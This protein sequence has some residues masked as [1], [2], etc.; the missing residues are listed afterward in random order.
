MLSVNCRTVSQE[1]TV[2]QQYTVY[3]K[4]KP[5]S[6]WVSSFFWI[7]LQTSTDTRR[8]TSNSLVCSAICWWIKGQRHWSFSASDHGNQHWSLNSLFSGSTIIFTY[9]E[10][11]LTEPIIFYNILN[12]VIFRTNI[13]TVSLQWLS[14]KNLLKI[15]LKHKMINLL[16]NQKQLISI[17]FDNIIIL[18]KS[19]F[20]MC[21]WFQL[22]K[23][24]D[25]LVLYGYLGIGLLIDST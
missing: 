3:Y 16:F 5:I 23:C 17:Y 11:T 24:E 4:P 25:L 7:N 10:K 6:P 9:Q 15:L 8:T 22:L 1:G 13:T 20:F 21:C 12:K 2:S 14:R 18:S 19:H